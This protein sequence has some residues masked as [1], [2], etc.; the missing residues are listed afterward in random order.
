MSW[1][2]TFLNPLP[3]I[4]AAGIVAP[5]LLVLYFLKL[6]RQE[7]AV[8]STLLWKKAVMDLQVNAPFQKLRRNLLLILQMLLLL[9]LCLALGRPVMNYTPG[10]GKTTVFL[11]DRSASMATK[12]PQLNGKTR[13]EE[14]KRRAKDLASTLDRNASAMVIAL[15]DSA[16]TVQPF[17]SDAAA[18]RRAIDSIQQTDRRTRLKLAYQLADAQANFNPEQLRANATKP[19]VL[20][21]SDGRVLDAPDE[22]RLTGDLKYERI[23]DDDAPNI[24]IV[25]L[26]AKRNYERPTEVQIFARLANYG[27]RPASADVQLSIDGQ[28]SKVAGVTLAPERWSD[29]AWVKAHPGEKDDNFAAKDSV[30]FTVDL[31]SSATI[32]VEQMNRD[33]DALSADDSAAVIVPPPKALAVLL[34]TDGNYYL[35]KVLSSLDLQKPDTMLPTAYETKKPTN[36][37]VIIFDRYQPKILP[38]SGSFIYFGAAPPESKLAAAKENGQP[39]IL[40]DQGVLDW[41]RDHPILRHLSLARLFFARSIKLDVPVEAEVLMDGLK[42]PLIVLYRD[43]RNTH[44]VVASDVLQSDW[45]LKVSFPVFMHNALQFLAV[46][47][48]M[49]VRQSYE[50]GATPRIS[51]VNLQKLGPD[52]K[53]IKLTGPGGSRDVP[54]TEGG[55]FA[56][57]ALDHVGIYTTEPAVPQFESIAVN[58]L[59]G[60]ESNVLPLED[61][62]PGG[63]GEVVERAGTKS[64]LELWWWIV[65][66]AALPLLLIE[67]WVYTRRVHL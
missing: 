25:A 51:R 26:S 52:V 61:R 45:P 18:V 3:A 16:E 49:D 14:A 55:D 47:S 24:A 46:G 40:D 57:P 63:V 2:P 23:G 41:K 67:W 36:Y 42:G 43:G 44:L 30:E 6:R 59:D 9:L 27:P 5:L 50:P 10:V 7:R 37:D 35:E 21:F 8:S 32:K 65:A 4:I 56:L 33:N 53:K 19:E 34:V 28:V 54:I 20:L 58:L 62:P 12:D 17:T 60:N 15:D 13:L 39:V 38:P 29:E 48:E 31:T 1:F 66:C 11:I 64:R 22:L